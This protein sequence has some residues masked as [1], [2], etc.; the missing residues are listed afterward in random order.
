MFLKSTLKIVLIAVFTIFS[1]PVV[2]ASE[3]KS[4]LTVMSRNL[5]LG[6]DVAVAMK[7]IPNMSKAAQFMWDQVA[8]TDFKK[9]AKVLANEITQNKPEVIGIQEATRW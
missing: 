1:T 8:V 7:L 5:Y 4:E 2:N 6:S 3:Q 9:R